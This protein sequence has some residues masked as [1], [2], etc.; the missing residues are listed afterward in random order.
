M[1][2]IV[3][4]CNTASRRMPASRLAAALEAELL[5]DLGLEDIR[6]GP[7][8]ALVFDDTGLSLQQ[9][10]RKA[11]GPVR[12][13]F[14]TGAVNH[15]RKFGGGKGQAIAKAVGIAARVKPY[16]LDATAGLGRDAFVL[17]TL[18]CQV[19]M[20]ERNPAVHALLSDGLARAAEQADSELAEIIAR[21]SLDYGDSSSLLTE[22]SN[23]FDVVYLDPMFP[24]RQKSAAVKK[25]MR[26]FHSLV[27]ADEDADGLLQAALEVARYR[28]VVKRP[29]NA[30]DL[31]ERAPSYRLEGK[32]GRFDIYALQKFPD[33]LN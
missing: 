1:T 28:V 19:H 8:F 29:R 4:V 32:S 12:A 33:S 7:E 30:P 9:T 10:G 21:L 18:G 2:D 23:G 15:R 13:E 17:A 11:P 20:H 16:V 14:V 27:G 25:E 26:A 24:E 6:E 22:R 3:V 31:A 5:F